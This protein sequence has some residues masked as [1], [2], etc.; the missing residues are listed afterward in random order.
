MKTYV[1]TGGA[2]FIGS[3]LSRRLIERG[4]EVYILDDL[5]TGFKRNIPKEAIF[6]KV[7]VSND[8]KLLNLR[9]P[10]KIDCIFH[11]AAQS[12]GEASF[13]DPQ[14]DMDVNY[15]A[16]Y[17]ILK[18]AKRKR[19]KRF[20]FSSSMSVYGE[21]PRGQGPIAE[22][23]PCK[24]LSY[25]GCNKLASEKLIDIF[26]KDMNINCTIFRLFNVYGPGQNMLNAKQGM[27]SIYLSY[28]LNDKVILVKGSGERFRDFIYIDDVIKVFMKSES[29]KASYGEIF[30]LGTSIKTTVFK[31]LKLILKTYEKDN[32]DKWIKIK[33]NTAG[34]VSGCVADNSKLKK[35]INL[36]P[37]INLEDGIGE[38]KKWLD[39]TKKFWRTF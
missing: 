20:I 10:N 11:L 13:D 35:L 32:F 2:G 9:L 23:F 38:T 15:K 17:N 33:G 12:S 16:T 36:V 26:A 5:S 25:Y 28:A 29:C 3:A 6:Y 1:I 7:D 31:L 39:Q 24:P 30:N 27:V 18:L 14:R 4:H 21:V 22:D 19:C 34:D 8:K 37:E